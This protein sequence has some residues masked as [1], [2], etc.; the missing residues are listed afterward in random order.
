ME[1][2]WRNPFKEGERGE[3]HLHKERA[4]PPIEDAA[5]GEPWRR[6]GGGEEDDL[7]PERGG[8]RWGGLGFYRCGCGR[9]FD[10]VW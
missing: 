7:V 1:K 6:L 4:L 2:T 9:R 10:W 5:A 8:N 3:L